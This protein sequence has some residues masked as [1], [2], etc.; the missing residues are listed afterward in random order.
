[1]PVV[2]RL[3]GK[4]YHFFSDEGNPLEPVHV[5][6]AQAGLDAKFWLFPDVR[7]AYNRGYDARTIK[8]LQE[9]V[10]AHREEIERAWNEHFSA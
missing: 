7:L 5:H 1:M 6:V 8:R 9:I 2:F 10:E 3:D 4:R